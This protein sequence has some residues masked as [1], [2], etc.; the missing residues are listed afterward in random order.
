MTDE[1]KNALLL[2]FMAMT[3]IMYISGYKH[4]FKRGGMKLAKKLDRYFNSTLYVE[5]DI[6]YMILRDF[7]NRGNK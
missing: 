2:K 7:L 6:V 1:E 4:G 5:P 3:L